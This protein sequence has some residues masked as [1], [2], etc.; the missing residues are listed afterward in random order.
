MVYP[1]IQLAQ[2][3]I[4]IC[5]AKNITNIVISPGSRNAP[6]TIGFASDSFFSCYSIAD[7]R[8]AAFFGMGIS[9][10]VTTPTVLVCTSGSALLNYYP[11][12]AEAFYSR[13]PLIVLSAD[14]PQHKIDIGDGQTIRQQN[15]FNNHIL[16]SANLSENASEENDVLINEAI[17]I[18]I[19]QGGPVHINAPF[20]EPLY[21]TVNQL[22]V[23]PIIIPT[24]AKIQKTIDYSHYS[25]IWNKATKKLI[26]VGEC[27]PN[28]LDTEI[29]NFLAK[30]ESVL[31]LAESISNINHP[32]IINAIDRLVIPFN[33]EELQQ[34]QPEI[35]ITFG[36]M[37]VSKKI[38]QILRQYKPAQHWHIDLSRHYNT[39]AVLTDAIEDCPN[40]FFQKLIQ[41]HQPI[42]S[43]YNKWAIELMASRN[44]LHQNYLETIPFCDFKAINSVVKLIPNNTQLQVSNSAVIRYVQLLDTKPSVTLFC[45]RGTSGID[46][47]TSTAIGAAVSSNLPTLLLTGDI[48]F[49][50]DSNGLWNSYIP[51]TFKI[52]II[53]NSGGGI[54]RTL[55]G[56]QDNNVFNTY[57]E[58]KHQLTAKHLANMY[59][60]NY[61]ETKS[62]NE[63]NK[64][65]EEFFASK[66]PSI[67]E[68][69]TSTNLNSDIFK[70]YYTIFK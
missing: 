43:D 68:I 60:F 25:S 33:E 66:S 70:A 29:L 22:E 26:L 3:L 37:I 65:L 21:N 28:S 5:K 42:T 7:E 9:Q 31:F 63:L 67:L 40:Q 34:F 62:E 59:N 11:A 12:I 58:T 16:F 50:Y 69:F 19:T 47:S 10:Q 23:D 57:F 49:L 20:E 36:G 30:E 1:T 46:G 56:H 32:G 17:N 55:P 4:S 38:K 13:I 18:A 6:L 45:N 48:S 27:K 15:V 39:F 8:C 52:V 24:S 35:L 53:N 51:D 41:M 64:N 61:L 14:R 44:L 54:F 2:S